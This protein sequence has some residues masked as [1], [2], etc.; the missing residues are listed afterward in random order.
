MTDNL[1]NSLD[2]RRASDALSKMKEER[3]RVST[4]Q[5]THVQKP[6][7]APNSTPKNTSNKD[8][9][10]NKGCILFLAVIIG[11][12]LLLLFSLF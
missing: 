2:A 11:I 8:N 3:Q 6:K 7:I 5:S 12:G 10:D 4:T 1:H 9:D